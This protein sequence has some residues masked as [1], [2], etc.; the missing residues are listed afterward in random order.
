MKQA[1][2]FSE[3]VA[4]RLTHDRWMPVSRQFKPYQRPPLF[5]WARNCILIA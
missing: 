1:M 5:P 2:L 4:N 3:P